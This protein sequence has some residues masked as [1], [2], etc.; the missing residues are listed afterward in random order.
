MSLVGEEAAT[1]PS[2]VNLLPKQQVLQ[3]EQKQHLPV[4]TMIQPAKKSSQK[5]LFSQETFST[6]MIMIVTGG[7]L[8]TAMMA[9]ICQVLSKN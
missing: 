4:R 2:I 6:E 3:Q 9:I 1:T 5:G 8:F 7:Q